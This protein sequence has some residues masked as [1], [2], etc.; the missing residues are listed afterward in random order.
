MQYVIDNA[1]EI[2]ESSQFVPLTDEQVEKAQSD[3]E[4]A[5]A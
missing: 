2:A 5:K 1:T 4:E 3:L